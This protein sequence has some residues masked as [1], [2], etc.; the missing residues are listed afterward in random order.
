MIILG[1]DPGIATVGYGFIDQKG[2]SL[3]PI[4]YGH[5]QTPATDTFFD[6]LLAISKALKQLILTYHPDVMAIEKIFFAKNTK[7]AMT[8]AQARGAILM[9][10]INL[11][12]G[13]YEYTPNEV[14]LA[15]TGYGAADKSQIQKMVKSLLN[16]VQIP[17]PDDTADALAIAI[18]HANSAKIKQLERSSV[19]V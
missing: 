2:N 4:H 8:V 5:I 1:L 3:T 7:T 11:G 16:L 6:R 15:V 19:H 13:I 18:C 9:E 12:L 17:K 14:K 10:A